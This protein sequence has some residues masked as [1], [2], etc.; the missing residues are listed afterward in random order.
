[1]FPYKTAM[2]GDSAGYPG[3]NVRR[4][5]VAYSLMAISVQRAND[6]EGFNGILETQKWT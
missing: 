1:M 2:I 5:T 6:K 3:W 4:I